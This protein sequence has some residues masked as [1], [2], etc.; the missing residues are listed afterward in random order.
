MCFTERRAGQRGQNAGETG[1]MSTLP[2]NKVN[3]RLFHAYKNSITCEV[4]LPRRSLLI[5][6]KPSLRRG[7]ETKSGGESRAENIFN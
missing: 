1:A 4:H 5:L 7:E 3:I 2:F 6:N